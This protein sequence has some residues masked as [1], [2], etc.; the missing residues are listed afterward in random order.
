[1]QQV[2]CNAIYQVE[3]KASINCFHLSIQTTIECLQVLLIQ[4]VIRQVGALSAPG[5]FGAADY[6]QCERRVC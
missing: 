3:T 6:T 4:A 1:M 5:N 2:C